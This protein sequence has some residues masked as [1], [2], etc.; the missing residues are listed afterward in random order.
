[1]KTKKPRKSIKAQ[2]QPRAA[3]RQLAKAGIKLRS[4]LRVGYHQ[5]G[6]MDMY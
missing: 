5:M 6:F 4:G 3:K 2:A 1:M